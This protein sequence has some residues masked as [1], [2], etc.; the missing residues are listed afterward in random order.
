M[1]VLILI[2][3]ILIYFLYK[4]PENFIEL[5]NIQ[6]MEIVNYHTTWCGYSKMFLP[7]WKDFEMKCKSKYPRI[8]VKDVV[9]DNGCSKDIRGFPTV[10]LYKNGKKNEYSGERTP[11]KI[12]HFVE[13]FL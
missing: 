8:K 4:K 9:C 10:I 1:L 3:I 2:I 13:T 11:E 5:D 12:M 7:I 6:D